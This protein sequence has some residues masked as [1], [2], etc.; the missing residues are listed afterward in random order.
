MPPGLT[1][2]ELTL[3]QRGDKV[4]EWLF[5]SLFPQRYH[6]LPLE[7]RA[8][9]ASYYAML[10][11]YL[12]AIPASESVKNR[13]LR[14]QLDAQLR[15]AKHFEVRPDLTQEEWARVASDFHTLKEEQLR[16]EG[17]MY[18]TLVKK[19]GRNRNH[20]QTGVVLR[21]ATGA[22][23]YVYD[24][25]Q[26]IVE[27]AEAMRAAKDGDVPRW[28]IIK[29][30]V[31]DDSGNPRFVECVDIACKERRGREPGVQGGRCKHDP[32]VDRQGRHMAHPAGGKRRGTMLY[33]NVSK[34]LTAAE[35]AAWSQP[36]A[37]PWWSNQDLK[38][39]PFEAGIRALP[40]PAQRLRYLEGLEE[41]SEPLVPWREDPTLVK[42]M[43]DQMRQKVMGHV[44]EVLSTLPEP[45]V[46]RQEADRNAVVAARSS[47]E[48]AASVLAQ[49]NVGA[50]GLVEQTP[51][52]AITD[53]APV[54]VS[55]VEEASSVEDT[56][57]SAPDIPVAVL[58]T[59]EQQQAWLRTREMVLTIARTKLRTAPTPGV[60]GASGIST[61]VG[62]SQVESPLVL[63]SA[64]RFA[65]LQVE[66]ANA[67][68]APTPSAS[69]AIG[70]Q[71][72]PR[73]DPINGSSSSSPVA[74]PQHT[75]PPSGYQPGAGLMVQRVQMLDP[76]GYIVSSQP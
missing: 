4:C 19:T 37:Y 75:Y 23:Q 33:D 42:K 54:V 30:P 31:L 74:P 35:K 48:A 47:A 66:S 14:T 9:A 29:K 34:P 56:G 68:I 7:G 10:L 44:D 1:G 63:T 49:G 5:D 71:V 55:A 60:A 40:D 22:P 64:N 50:A 57:V 76:L 17:L 67:S 36:T 53:I 2:S 20:P 8:A 72:D 59:I 26:I 45:A 11:R 3:Q 61:E 21:D 38:D 58:D 52:H 24:R 39:A 18:R 25:H 70:Q 73:S 43:L 27:R 46:Q 6:L 69:P 65:V 13:S 32:L 15:V 16:A 51:Q 28:K 62:L 41:K 12:T